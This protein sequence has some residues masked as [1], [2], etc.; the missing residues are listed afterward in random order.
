MDKNIVWQQLF[1]ELTRLI[2]T[3]HAAAKRAHDTATNDQNVAENKY[4]TLG[5][6]AAYLAQGQQ[7]RMAQCETD[8]ADYQRLFSN[9]QC[10]GRVRLG[11]LVTVIDDNDR[12][13]Y[14]FI[15]MA[16]GGVKLQIGQEQLLVIT[17]D[18]PLGKALL[19][20]EVDDD[21]TLSIGGKSIA[22]EITAIA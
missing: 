21:I 7:V 17:P 11:S 12:H 18:A 13:C 20:R 6:E 16:A 10:D 15:G 8:L 3:A 2:D 14:F 5:L 4:D 1:S 9:H 19:N 22:Y